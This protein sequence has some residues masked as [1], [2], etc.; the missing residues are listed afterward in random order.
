MGLMENWDEIRT[1]F[2]VARLGTVSGAAEVLGVHHATVIRHIDAL[3]A[4]LGV[5]LFQRHARGYTATEAGADLLRVAQATDDQFGQLAGRIKGRGTEVSGDLVVTSLAGLSQSVAPLLVAFQRQY[6]E[7]IVRYLTG[8]RLFRLEYGEAHVAIRA[9]TVPDQPDNVV[10]PLK[11][12][13]TGAYASR[14]YVDRY[15]VPAGPEDY[16]KHRFVGPE[17]PDSRAPFNIWLRENVPAAAISFRC[18]DVFSANAAV[19]AGAGIGFLDAREAGLY[20]DLVE[21]HAPR[22]EWSGPLWLVTHVDLHR[23][24]KVQALLQFIKD[25]VREGA[26]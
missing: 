12:F 25:Q 8:D 15:G 19:M 18:T 2:Q 22:P 5:K 13:E 11:T 14:D 1:A 9:G 23:T 24:T 16:P 6:P 3:E 4:R 21:I 26:F 7:V 10:Q 17:D 20:P